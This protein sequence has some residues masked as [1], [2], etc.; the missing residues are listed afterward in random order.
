MYDY[1]RSSAICAAASATYRS[2]PNTNQ[3]SHAQVLLPYGPCVLV[4]DGLGSHS[5]AAEAAR[6]CTER[7][8]SLLAGFVVPPS[9]S[10]LVSAF[11]SLNE[12]LQRYGNRVG[13]AV[14]RDPD[15]HKFMGT[16][17]LIGCE[18]PDE[19]L[20]SYVGNGAAFRLPGNFWQ[21]PAE[22]A[23]PWCW[24][25]LL[26]PHTMLQDGKEVLIRYLS[27]ASV[28]SMAM[29]SAL[30]IDKDSEVGDVLIVAT[31]G[32]FSADQA[33]R[34]TAMGT[35]WIE[36][37]ANLVALHRVLLGLFGADRRIEV[38]DL[39]SALT[40]YL[41][42]L[43]SNGALEDDA[44]IAIIVTQDAVSYQAEAHAQRRGKEGGDDHS[45]E[46]RG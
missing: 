3:D 34:G 32:I 8:A 4:A 2:D 28:Q 19:L 43:A 31:D 26:C 35:H 12:E 6:F 36:A 22:V 38:A 24:L 46:D 1:G 29:P 14:H 27:P 18:M 11:H 37:G 21:F 25:N 41:G 40:G 45:D 16:T 39:E 44:S 10:E 20:I 9:R 5:C 17:L 30:R 13:E 7:M 42:E 33:R 23:L 15:D